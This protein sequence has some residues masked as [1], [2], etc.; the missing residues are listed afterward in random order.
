MKLAT[1]LFDRV[2]PSVMDHEAISGPCTIPGGKRTSD[3]AL[4]FRSWL[5]APLRAGAF[6]PSSADLA[7]AM[8]AQVDP[9]LPGPVVELGPGTSAVTAALVERG[10][11]PARLLLIEADPVFCALLRERWP[12]AHV[13]NTDA[14]AAPALIKNLGEPAA[15]IVAGLP[16]IVKPPRQRLRLVLDSLRHAAPGAPFVQFTYF[17]R[18]PVPAPRPGLRAHGSPMVWWNLWPARVWSYRL[19]NHGGARVGRGPS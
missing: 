17:V 1:S 5:E 19:T 4:F 15:A 10:V 9:S 11:D 8:A 6:K 7:R 16:L 2:N 14:Y 18:S 12:S 3:N 13:L